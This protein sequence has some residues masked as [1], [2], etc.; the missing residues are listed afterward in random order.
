MDEPTDDDG[1][2]T[3]DSTGRLTTTRRT[4]MKAGTV[5]LAA[6]GTFTTNAAA[7]H[8]AGHGGSDGGGGTSAANEFS[9]A[10]ENFHVMKTVSEPGEETVVR[11]LMRV[12]DVKQSN[13]WQDSLLLQPSVETSLL[14]DV[15]VSG[16]EDASRAF[17]GVLGWV[18]IRGDATGGRWQMV[19]VDDGLVDPPQSGDLFDSGNVDRAQEIAQGVVAFDTRDLALEWDLTAITDQI[20]DFDEEAVE[21]DDLFLD[22]YMRTKS[23]NSFDWVKTDTGGTNDVRFMGALHVFVDADTDASVEAQAIVGNRTMFVDPIKTKARVSR[24]DDA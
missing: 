13:S 15:E 4:A 21:D 3:D 9:F 12:E 10:G 5:G 23:A 22:V 19:T 14:T 20:T 7:H 1:R 2:R 8:K 6:L 11:E 18:E 16:T 17:A 24:L